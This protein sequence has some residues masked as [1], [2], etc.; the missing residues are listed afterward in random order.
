MKRLLYLLHRWVGIALC[1][2][3]ALWFLSGMVL[4]Y[5]GYPKLT[6]AEQ[7]QGLPV[8]KPIPGCCVPLARALDASGLKAPSQ[9]RLAAV[10]GTPHYLFGDGRRTAVAVN[11][12]TG[13]RVTA[14]GPEAASVSASHFAAG[15]PVRWLGQDAEDAWTH[16]RALDAHRPLHRV[17]V[18]DGSGLWLYVSG[19]TGEVVRDATR[20]ERRWGWVGAWLHWLYI[21]RGGALNAWWTDI[22]IWLSIAGAALGLSGLVVGVWRWRFKGRYKSGSRS[23]YR[24]RLAR[25]HHV[26]GLTGGT[27]ALTWVVSGL[28]SMNPWKVFDAPGAKPDRL[29]Y[30]GGP[31]RADDAPDAARVLA[32]LQEQ[33]LQPRLLEWRRVAGEPRML[34][35]TG[36]GQF[37]VDGDGRRQAPLSEAALADAAA[38]LLPKA[39]I[40]GREWLTAYDSHYYSRD[41]HTMTGGRERPLPALRLR[42]DDAQ[43]HEV[44]LDPA[45]GAVVQTSN[46][47][48]RVD[49]WLFAFL[50]SF[51]LPVL[52]NARPAWD[53]WMLGFS[54]AGMALS[55]TGV[56]MGWRRLR[57]RVL[58]RKSRPAPR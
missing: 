26:I 35:Q 39:R 52:L 15:A 5:V 18:E 8:L 43:A 33:G 20:A 49:R 42:F 23:P 57:G 45:T 21:F 16:S 36:A 46:G 56:V 10:A 47:H 3:M 24:G 40:V 54:L 48:Q 38:R 9:W 11:A 13:E 34:V 1:V 12:V 25:W 2:V 37:L 6:P 44:V 50:H 41:A 29:A 19:N 55:V 32:A 51:D 30:A 27:L 4:L 28:L 58:A 22:V 17:A 53:A 31:L 7:L 14:V